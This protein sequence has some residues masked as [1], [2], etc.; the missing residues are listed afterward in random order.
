VKSKV[1]VK[2]AWAQRA[3]VSSELEPPAKTRAT[4]AVA[5]LLVATR[6]GPQAVC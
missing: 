5:D 1:N 6:F 3:L 4:I 2:A